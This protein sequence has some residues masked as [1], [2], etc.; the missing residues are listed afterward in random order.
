MWN[1]ILWPG[2]KPRPLALIT[3]SL[4]YWTTGKSLCV[5]LYICVLVIPWTV[6]HLAPLSMGILQPRITG[7]GCHALLQGIFPTQ[8]S[9]WGLLPCR[10]ILYQLNYQGSPS[11]HTK[12]CIY[13]CKS[14]PLSWQRVFYAHKLLPDYFHYY[15]KKLR[16]QISVENVNNER[17]TAG[18]CSLSSVL[19]V[20]LRWSVGWRWWEVST[21]PAGWWALPWSTGSIGTLKRDQISWEPCNKIGWFSFPGPS[22]WTRWSFKFPLRLRFCN[23]LSCLVW[24]PACP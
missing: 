19:F 11:L 15:L 5:Y 22:D 7:V 14:S 12:I 18:S 16:K 23:H 4:G 1:A 9:N 13:R 2:I 24:N 8:G 21:E 3:W 10:Q 6:A 20:R 17:K